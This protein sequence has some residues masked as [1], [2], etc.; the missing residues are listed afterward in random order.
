MVACLECGVEVA[1]GLLLK[2]RQIQ[3]VMGWG[4]R[5]GGT[6]PPPSEAQTYRVSFPKH[7]WWLQCLVEGCLG[8]ASD[9]TNLRVHFAHNHTRDTIVIL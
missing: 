1:S 4:Y 3:H 9:W 6:S 8:G 7:L 5:E 2:K